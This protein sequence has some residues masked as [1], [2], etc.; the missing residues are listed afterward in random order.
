MMSDRYSIAG[1]ISLTVLAVIALSTLLAPWL[2]PYDPLA[3]DYEEQLLPPSSAH[4]FGT[5]LFG[6]DVFTRVLYGARISLS[7]GMLAALL[8][9]LPGL[10]L[11]LLS[12]YYGGPFDQLMMRLTDVAL[13]FPSL[14]L[15]LGIVAILEPGLV[16]VTI[17]V[18][19]AGIPGYVRLVR[20]NVLS[21]K[22][23][24][25]IEAAQAIGCRHHRIILRH[26]L[27][28]I[29]AS[30]LVLVTMDVAWAILRA[31]SLSF[32]GL[33]AQPPTP[34]WGAMI[35]E[36]RELLRRAPWVSLAPSAVM[37]LAVLSINLV[38]DALRDALDPHTVSQ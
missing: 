23:A 8:A 19:L 35:D 32:L 29:S 27:P 5:D 31:T 9:A 22:E 37:M 16:N 30:V 2:T 33:G 6:R 20:G 13:A 34:E 28:N 10:L 36:G 24:L 12:G 18:G 4:L 3:M 26:I 1:V 15:S 17:A 25:Y 38:G 14:I 7:V 11:G 21:V